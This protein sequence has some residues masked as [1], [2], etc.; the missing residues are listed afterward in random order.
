M[1]VSVAKSWR[2]EAVLQAFSAVAISMGPA[3]LLPP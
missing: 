3:V 2:P 1:N